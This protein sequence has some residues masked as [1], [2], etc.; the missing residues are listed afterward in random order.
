MTREEPVSGLVSIGEKEMTGEDE[1]AAAP[2]L[3]CCRCQAGS[4]ALRRA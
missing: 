2:N 4:R 3:A 1:A